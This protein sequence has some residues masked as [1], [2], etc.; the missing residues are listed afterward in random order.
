MCLSDGISVNEICDPWV[1]SESLLPRLSSSA[2][3]ALAAK[4]IVRNKED[5]MDRPHAR[6][7]AALAVGLLLT[8]HTRSASALP[9]FDGYISYYDVAT[10]AASSR[11]G[12]GGPGSSGGAGDNTVRIINP[13][14]ETGTQCAEIYVFDDFE[15]LQTC[16]GC[17]VSPDG[18]RTLSVLNDLTS[19]FGVHLADLNEGVVEVI[20]TPLDFF[21]QIAPGNPFPPGTNGNDVAGC[22]PTGSFGDPV[23]HRGRLVFSLVFNVGLRLWM[24]HDESQRPG[25]IGEGRTATGIS[26]ERFLE[27]EQNLAELERLQ[28]DCAT[29]ISNSSGTGVCTCGAGDNNIVPPLEIP[30]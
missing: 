2:A 7:L 10:S 4:A 5:T 23:F 3:R 15:E 18:Q 1:I 16:C 13:N 9:E 24:T 25:N 11:A 17:P 20:T 19:N 22:T 30:M 6:Y 29:L 26:S 28:E 21:P 27:S 8:A 12:Y 14:L